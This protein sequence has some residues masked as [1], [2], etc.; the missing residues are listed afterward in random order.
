MAEA[1]QKYAVVTGANKGI[2]LETCRQLASRGIT[3][4]L[5]ARDKNKGREAVEKFGA[6]GLVDRVIFHRLDVTDNSTITALAEFIKSQF[7]RLDILVNNAGVLGSEVE[8][9]AIDFT[10][11]K[12]PDWSK[13]ATDI[14]YEST[15]DAIQTNYYGTKRI[16]EALLPFLQLSNS[17]R[18]VNVSSTLGNLKYIP[19]E[20]A[21]RIL[22]DE[23]NLTEEQIDG[24]VNEFLKDSKE[25]EVEA[26]GWP[27]PLGGYMVSKAAMNAYTRLLAKQYPRFRINCLCPGLVKTDITRNVGMWTAEEGA[28]I[29]VMLATLP[30]DGPTGRH[31]YRN[32]VG[33]F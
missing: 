24:I 31:F 32:T 2:G 11:K 23:E 25:E 27:K 21:R 7:G 15:K 6:S 18:I 33:D 16:T 30:D 10:V 3:V 14:S 28:E 9:E 13:I 17:P 20:W 19:S 1:P 12:E 5:T 4:V 22:N 29:P 8:W 26:K